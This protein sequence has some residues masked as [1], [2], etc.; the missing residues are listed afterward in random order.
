MLVILLL[1]NNLTKIC[2]KIN[3]NLNKFMNNLHL[4]CDRHRGNWKNWYN[5]NARSTTN[6]GSLHLKLFSRW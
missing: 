5:V 3:K 1:I 6:D 4:Q 2:S